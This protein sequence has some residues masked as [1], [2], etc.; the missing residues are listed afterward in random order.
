MLGRGC[1]MRVWAILGGILR[2]RGI[3]LCVVDGRVVRIL[4]LSFV[5]RSTRALL[6]SGRRLMR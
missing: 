1:T 6:E 2:I 5:P 4:N 3:G